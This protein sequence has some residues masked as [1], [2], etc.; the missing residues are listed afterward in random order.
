MLVSAHLNAA[1]V[2]PSI[3]LMLSQVRSIPCHLLYD[4]LTLGLVRIPG[5]H[6]CVADNCQCSA[7]GFLVCLHRDSQGDVRVSLFFPLSS[8]LIMK[9]RSA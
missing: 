4:R 9:S 7:I 8:A 5:I 2:F 1:N 6:G 3:G